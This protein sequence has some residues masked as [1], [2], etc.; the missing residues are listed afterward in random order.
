MQHGSLY[1]NLWLTTKNQFEMNVE[2]KATW[3][4]HW[5][6]PYTSFEKKLNVDVN[7]VNLRNNF[8]CLERKLPGDCMVMTYKA[9]SCWW[10][11]MALC[12]WFHIF[13]CIWKC[14][15]FLKRY[16]MWTCINFIFIFCKLFCGLI[17]VILT[18][19]FIFFL[20]PLKVTM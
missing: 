1:I 12:S 15:S 3:S 7:Y 18:N 20:G 8:F 14:W 5:C 10:S 17:F 4:V 13:Q 2:I 19:I 6:A 11:K 9:F 16:I